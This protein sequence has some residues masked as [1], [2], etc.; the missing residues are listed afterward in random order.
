MRHSLSYSHSDQA[1]LR[2]PRLDVCWDGLVV[3]G[4]LATYYF[5]G[6]GGFVLTRRVPY[7]LDPRTPL[8]QTIDVGRPPPKASHLKLAAI[9][10]PEVVATWPEHEIQRGH[11]ED[12]RWPAV[13][14]RVLDFQTAYSETATAKVDKYN[15]L[16]EEAG[17]PTMDA[18]PDDPLRLVPPYWSVGEV[19]DPW[20]ALSKQATALA[21]EDH[22]GRILPII[23][24]ATDVD[25]NVF[26]ELIDD[27]PDGSDEVFCW[28]SNWNEAD[29]TG[30]DVDGWLRAVAAG[31]RRGI[32][33]RNLYGGYLSVLLTARG[34]AGVNHGVG[35]SESRDSR[36]LSATGA[37]QARYYLPTLREF[38]TV[39]NAQPV[40]D[41][42][43]VEW[44]CTCRV[45]QA[46]ADDEGR[47]QVGRLNP[48]GLKRHFLITRH[49][50]FVRVSN[51]FDRELADL[52]DVG[53]W[54]VENERRF[55]VAEHGNRL[56]RWADS[57][58]PG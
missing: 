27:L 14:R 11:W 53:T 34:L 55:L 10:D 5:E 50:E 56:L 37:P 12:G 45:C 6:T 49:E 47:P 22:P 3:P 13:V 43:P 9:H 1:L 7:V 42:L 15:R 4:T 19:T 36:R 52:V 46:V 20:W 40:I 28:A 39:P 35:Y 8:L 29:A 38:F 51:D 57:V 21:L 44:A 17:L 30:E 2:D 41:Y 31:E 48:E 25:L 32:T 26:A 58:R 16:L 18:Q 23:A 24:L 54:V 33:V